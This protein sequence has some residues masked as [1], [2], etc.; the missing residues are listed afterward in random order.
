MM[1]SVDYYLSIAKHL[2]KRRDLITT[3][4]VRGPSKHVL[5]PESQAEVERV[6]DHLLTLAKET[7]Q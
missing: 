3:T 5:D 2:L 7:N 6:Y 1:N 4:H